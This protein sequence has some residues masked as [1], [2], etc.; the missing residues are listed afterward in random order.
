MWN[1]WPARDWLTYEFYPYGLAG[2]YF[3]F[4]GAGVDH[5]LEQIQTGFFLDEYLPGIP[6]MET[7]GWALYEDQ[8]GDDAYNWEIDA[9]RLPVGSTEH[10][11]GECTEWSALF[12]KTI[13][14]APSGHT[15]VLLGFNLDRETDY[16]VEHIRVR[17][18]KSGTTLYLDMYY[19]DD[20]GAHPTCYSVSYAWV[21]LHRVRNL[22]DAH[23]TSAG[24]DDAQPIDAQQPI[25]Q[26]FDIQFTNGDHHVDEV[27][28]QVVPGEVRVWLN[29]QNDDDPFSWHVWWADLE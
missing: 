18:Y 26:G 10:Q 2:F 17:L 28:V 3:N 8:N 29:D 27:G 12:N 23:S 22:D 24:N 4:T 20:G 11:V 9:Q 16:N 15:P 7:A 5:Q 14:Q 6:G 21:P 25:L 1:W 19:T 13:G